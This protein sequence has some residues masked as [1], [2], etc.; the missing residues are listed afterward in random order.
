MDPNM[1]AIN[2][3][4]FTAAFQD[5]SKRKECFQPQERIWQAKKVV[6]KKLGQ[7]DGK[8]I[9]RFI[10]TYEQIM[11]DN[12]VNKDDYMENFNKVAETDL[13]DRIEQL[14]ERRMTIRGKRSRKQ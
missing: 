14:F 5:Q 3:N 6:S 12:G 2:F 4:T 1:N 11:E 7:F 8:N 10:K 13:Q 9:T